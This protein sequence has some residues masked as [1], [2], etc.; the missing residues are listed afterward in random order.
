LEQVDEHLARAD[1]HLRVAV[2]YA[3]AQREPHDIGVVGPVEP[4]V[5]D[6]LFVDGLAVAT[7]VVVGAFVVGFSADGFL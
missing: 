2:L 4:V 5:F 3:A 7:V 6:G 1:K